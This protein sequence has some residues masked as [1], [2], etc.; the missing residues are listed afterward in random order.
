[1]S[2]EFKQFRKWAAVHPS[3]LA[4]RCLL[5]LE[6]LERGPIPL[7]VKMACRAFWRLETSLRAA[8]D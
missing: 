4:E 6:V 5:H 2:V 1:M 8:R 7:Q 3:P